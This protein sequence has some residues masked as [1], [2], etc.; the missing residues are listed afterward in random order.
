MTYISDAFESTALPLPIPQAAFHIADHFARQQPTVAKAEQVRLNTLAVWVINDYLQLMGIATQLSASDSWNPVMQLAANTAD[1]E[2]VGAGRLEC[3]PWVDGSPPICAIPPEVWHDR[4][5]YVVV[6]IN[7]TDRQAILL[8]FKETVA[9][10]ELPIRDLQ[11]PEAV[12]DHLD[13]LLHSVVAVPPTDTQPTAVT[14]LSLWFQ[15]LMDAGWQTVEALL[16]PNVSLAYGFR[17]DPGNRLETSASIRRAKHI[18]VGIQPSIRSLILIVE[19][20]PTTD[21]SVHICIQLHPT[22]AIY[23]PANVQ[24][25]V[26]DETD[27]VFLNAQ[28]REIDNYIQ[29]ELSGST[30]EA[31]SIQV[32]VG[33]D[34]IIEQFVI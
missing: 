6:Q 24:L 30:G 26:L 8:G 18:N 28:S 11:P 34:R 17:G 19:L 32:Q 2:I 20:T 23:L 21:E 5:G 4:I 9:A 31:F 16:P 1:L 14:H 10:E 25:I 12:L 33:T 15:N 22:D 7:E 29:L 27:T 3:R 13:R